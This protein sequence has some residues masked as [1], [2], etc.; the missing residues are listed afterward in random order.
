M[1]SRGRALPETPEP[2]CP[3]CRSGRTV[4]AGHVIVVD[5]KIKEERRC[6]GC[7]TAFLVVRVAL[8]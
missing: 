4:A 3:S 8:A 2:R 7:Q 1:P 5:R 6:E